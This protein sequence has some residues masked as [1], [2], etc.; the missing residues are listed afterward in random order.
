MLHIFGKFVGKKL[1]TGFEFDFWHIYVKNK[2]ADYELD[3]TMNNLNKLRKSVTF[4]VLREL[5]N[6][7]LQYQFEDLGFDS[8][9]KHLG[10][11]GFWYFNIHYLVVCF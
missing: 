8:S 3:I 9:C 7:W 2:I 1:Q 10:N 5:E 6:I 11:T 4:T